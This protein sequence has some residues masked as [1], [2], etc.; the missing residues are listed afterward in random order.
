[1]ICQTC[2]G[3]GFVTDKDDIP[4]PDCIGGVA[5]CC[6]AAGSSALDAIAERCPIC[7]A[8]WDVHL[9][10]GDPCILMGDEDDDLCPVCEGEGYI[11]EATPDG[12]HGP[13]EHQS[14]FIAKGTDLDYRAVSVTAAGL[15]AL[16]PGDS[17]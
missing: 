17:E 15:D 4:C 2:H 11:K 7:G 1:M 6:D 8:P 3:K 5:S 10:A 16:Q 9:M 14:S 13:G 12:G